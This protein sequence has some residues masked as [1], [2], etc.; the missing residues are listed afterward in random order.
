VTGCRMFLIALF[1]IKVCYFYF[2]LNLYQT[3]K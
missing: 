1:M 3:I 2:Q